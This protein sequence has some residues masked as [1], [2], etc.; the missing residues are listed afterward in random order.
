MDRW[1]IKLA[2]AVDGCTHPLACFDYF[3]L[4]KMFLVGSEIVHLAQY[5]SGSQA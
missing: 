2:P 3:S 1:K 4:A 5:P